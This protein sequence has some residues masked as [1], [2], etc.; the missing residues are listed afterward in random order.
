MDCRFIIIVILLLILS[1]HSG[2]NPFGSGDVSSMLS[3]VR[4][5]IKK[6]FILFQ[7]SGS[8]GSGS[9]GS[10]DYILQAVNKLQI[11]SEKS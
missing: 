11:K 4:L 8:S 7:S 9:G 2:S 3:V 5:I 1:Y 6:K 10:G